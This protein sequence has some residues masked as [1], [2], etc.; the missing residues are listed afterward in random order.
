MA[1]DA[2]KVEERAV[3]L[4]GAA[5]S[6]VRSLQTQLRKIQEQTKE[7]EVV[8][9]KALAKK[10]Q[11]EALL[12]AARSRQCDEVLEELRAQR[13]EDLE[14]QRSLAFEVD[15]AERELKK[16]R[17]F[18]E[19]AASRADF[20]ALQR[21]TQQ[22]LTA[23][24]EATL[25]GH[26]LKAEIEA[27]E[28]NSGEL[29]DEWQ[30]RESIKT[31]NSV[32]S[33]TQVVGLKN[34]GAQIATEAMKAQ[35][36]KDLRR[37]AEKISELNR[38]KELLRAEYEHN[39]KEGIALE[40]QLDAA[41]AHNRQIETQ[42]TQL[43]DAM[44]SACT[45]LRTELRRRLQQ[46]RVLQDLC[47]RQPPCTDVEANSSAPRPA[48]QASLR[49]AS[50]PFWSAS[51]GRDPSPCDVSAEVCLSSFASNEEV[52]FGQLEQPSTWQGGEGAVEQLLRVVEENALVPVD[53]GDSANSSVMVTQD[54]SCASP[55]SITFSLG[56]PPAETS[57]NHD[58]IKAGDPQ[59]CGS[60]ASTPPQA[61]EEGSCFDG[62]VVLQG[63]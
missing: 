32:G 48:R 4:S 3:G 11:K 41:R 23:V 40:Y 24:E 28:L 59:G 16:H 46:I 38:R 13:L 35:R 52:S 37:Q 33:K 61:P 27:V 34:A 62:Q 54:A 63:D 9:R 8:A 20:E 39:C 53:L 10:E 45:M 22:M 60:V 12:R 1:A 57:G 56:S 25:E 17:A 58:V 43:R 55:G 47:Q 21:Q 51:P 42:T 49:T 31:S 2:G 29:V 44:A 26:R 50:R 7:A 19:S 18:Q 6:T 14:L 5:L 15:A 30:E 36:A